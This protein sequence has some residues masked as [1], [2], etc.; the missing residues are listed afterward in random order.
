MQLVETHPGCLAGQL[1]GRDFPVHD[2]VRRAQHQVVVRVVPRRLLQHGDRR[3]RG[4]LQHRGR[5]RARLALPGAGGIGQR[6]RAGAA[7]S[8]AAVGGVAGLDDRLDGT[9]DATAPAAAKVGRPLARRRAGW[10][11]AAGVG[12][13]SGTAAA[14]P[15][16]VLR[17]PRA[18]P[19]ATRTAA[20]GMLAPVVADQVGEVVDVVADGPEAAVV[21]D[22][23]RVGRLRH[24][25]LVQPH[26]G[27]PH[28]D[29]GARVQFLHVELHLDLAD[30]AV[31]Q[32]QERGTALGHPHLV[33][34][35]GA[36]L[37]GGVPELVLEGQRVGCALGHRGRRPVRT[38][39]LGLPG[40]APQ[41]DVPAG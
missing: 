41:L 18:G 22:A 34:W 8:A 25:L 28:P 11:T 30:R 13:G 35:P 39:A 23:D 4:I 2:A 14:R 5:H 20:A 26:V 24:A 40:R 7:D 19:A 3:V 9:D 32:A 1:L 15:R 12:S 27:E 31:R 38:D 21:G 6:V 36:Q 17:S 37:G 33:Q 16:P 29:L 10:R